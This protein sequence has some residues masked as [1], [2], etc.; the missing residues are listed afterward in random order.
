MSNKR[1]WTEKHI[2][3]LVRS[4]ARILNLGGREEIHNYLKRITLKEPLY[5]NVVEA[6][7]FP[8]NKVKDV[9][10]C[11]I[12][13]NHYYEILN[14]DNVLYLYTVLSFSSDYSKQNIY[15]FDSLKT[16]KFIIDNFYSDGLKNEIKNKG[17]EFPEDDNF[18]A[19]YTEDPEFKAYKISKILNDEIIITGEIGGIFIFHPVGDKVLESVGDAGKFI[20]DVNK[21]IIYMGNTGHF[22][23]RKD[24][25]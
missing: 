16:L 10:N 7:F 19:G 6:R 22:I 2:R 4:E 11:K 5:E 23:K 3:E 15:D 12:K 20:Y 24:D 17:F 14:N 21:Y 8:N 13:I 1:D 25:K 9:V 18:W